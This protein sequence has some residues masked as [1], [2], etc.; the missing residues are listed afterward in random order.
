MRGKMWGKIIIFRFTPSMCVFLLLMESMLPFQRIPFI[1]VLC[2]CVCLITDT[3]TLKNPFLHNS[4]ITVPLL[5]SSWGS[6]PF[7]S[8]E[9]VYVCVNR[10]CARIAYT[11]ASNSNGLSE[12]WTNQ[13]HWKYGK[14]PLFEAF[15]AVTLCIV[16]LHEH[17][18]KCSFEFVTLL[19][20][21]KKSVKLNC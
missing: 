7:G 12:T 10:T 6:L 19:I 8:W 17:T 9:R 3:L 16:N 1:C 15:L 5:S 11:F 21:K 18:N 20:E 14:K 13:Y 4:K 2:Q